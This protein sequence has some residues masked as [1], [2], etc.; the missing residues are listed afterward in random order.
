MKNNPSTP[1]L[2]RHPRGFAL[3]I[4]VIC[5]VA[6]VAIALAV[7]F[8]AGAN[9]I[10]S[11][12]GAA[13]DHAE[14]IAVAGME[15]AVAFAEA[16]AVEQRDY[17]LLL[18]RN[19]DAD[20]A[21]DALNPAKIAERGLP[22]FT[23]TGS[24]DRTLD[25]K[26]YRMVPFNDGAYLVRFDDD[27][28]DI[29]DNG[30]LAPFTGNH[31]S[32]GDCAEGPAFDAG[33][34]PFRDRNRGIWV[35]V[36]GIYPGTDPARA[37]H[38]VSLSRYHVSTQRLPSYGFVTGGKLDVD[39]S[40]TFCSKD[41]DISAG[42]SI[43]LDGGDVCGTL[44]AKDNINAPG[45]PSSAPSVCG[46]NPTATGI[47]G[48]SGPPSEAAGV[49]QPAEI[50]AV[51]ANLATE[52]SSSPPSQSDFE[53]WFDARNNGA[54]NVIETEVG[55]TI[56]AVLGVAGVT[57]LRGLWFRDQRSGCTGTSMPP[58]PTDLNFLTSCW[59][60]LLVSAV[61]SGGGTV[62]IALWNWSQVD[63][64]SRVWRPAGSETQTFLGLTST[65]PDFAACST[66]WAPSDATNIACSGCSGSTVAVKLDSAGRAQIDMDNPE[67]MPAITLQVQQLR[68][69][70]SNVPA[71]YAPNQWGL[72]TVVVHDDVSLSGSEKLSFG[73]ARKSAPG[74][75]AY[76]PS[77]VVRGKLKLEVNAQIRTAGGLVV[78]KEIELKGNSHLQTHGPVIVRKSVKVDNSATLVT[79]VQRDPLER[80]TGELVAA[81]TTARAQR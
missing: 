76:Y 4:V 8:T 42:K 29:G 11:V 3:I 13:I 26:R 74:V 58:L 51:I 25:G 43:K 21:A 75:P 41:T 32:G 23:D 65:L 64:T 55:G 34:N 19:L 57:A 59:R 33:N 80:G 5:S 37:Q 38:R 35:S 71:S 27:A 20:C 77:L 69:D 56:G 70:G 1:D 60:P 14:T 18:D 50:L 78:G 22:E 54:C 48:C 45:L 2:P 63:E 68:I 44:M 16:V 46:T 15:R 7:A 73:S 49:E 24:A 61:Q 79:H 47:G 53:Q 40:M 31:N 36:V 67:A 12:K 9:K 10:V 17:D 6:M 39:S 52:N 72:A 81:P 66:T 62:P 30:N 28:D